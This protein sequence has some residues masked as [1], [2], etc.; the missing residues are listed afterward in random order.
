ML[1]KYGFWMLALLLLVPA[2]AEAERFKDRVM[3]VVQPHL[4]ALR[5]ELVDLIGDGGTASAGPQVHDADGFQVGQ[6]TSLD[7]NG[8]ATVLLD[9]GDL[10]V[11]LVA[12]ADGF[13]SGRGLAFESG[14]CTGTPYYNMDGIR[15]SWTDRAILAWPMPTLYV[16]AGERALVSR[17]SLLQ[18]SGVCEPYNGSTE[19][20]NPVEAVVDLGALYPTPYELR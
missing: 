15:E 7:R 6:L 1:R 19:L 8:N 10:T 9:V 4:D 20:L 16:S 12:T 5:A 11:L 18:A 14:D 2:T 13:N 17:G 3:S